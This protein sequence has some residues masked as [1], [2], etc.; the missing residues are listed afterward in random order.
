MTERNIQNFY[1]PHCTMPVE[2]EDVV[3]Q[4]IEKEILKKIEIEWEEKKLNEIE[5]VRLDEQ[6]KAK[7]EAEMTSEKKLKTHI[8]MI[9][10]KYEKEIEEK[11]ELITRNKNLE[12]EKSKI[13][14]DADQI[15]RDRNIDIKSAV[16]KAV[17]ENNNKKETA[18]QIEIDER[19]YQISTLKNDIIR[20]NKKIQQGSIQIQGETGEFH[21]EKLLKDLFPTDKI[22]PVKQG[23]P[24]ADCLLS[25]LSRNFQEVGSIYFEIKRTKEFSMN[26][27]KKLHQDIVN[28][29]ADIGVIVTETM[30]KGINQADIVDGIWVCGFHEVKLISKLLKNGLIEK[31]KILS[32]EINRKQKSQL[33]YKYLI[34]N[35]FRNSVRQLV[36]TISE[37]R[38][39][40]FKELIAMQ[41]SYKAKDKLIE[42]VILSTANIVEEIQNISG[43][44]IVEIEGLP[45]LEEI[46]FADNNG[47]K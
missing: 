9:S 4:S 17:K 37:L 7:K 24:G 1:C 11:K 39:R 16:L 2:L 44:R 25:I 35:Q 41:R 26:W 38:E 28:I 42:Q 40:N 43:K 10:E 3:K 34:S 46:D 8:E 30:P 19:D 15:K 13:E 21:I 18:M 14:K 32:S 45:S 29:N 31:S 23:R 12:M 5:K 20:I 22:K 33:I 36:G 6:K 47:F 27:I